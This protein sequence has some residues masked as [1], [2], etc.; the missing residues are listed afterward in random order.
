[1][2]FDEV[3]AIIPARGGSKGI[4]RKNIVDLGGKPLVAY[5][6][7]AALKSP[8]ISRVIVS[9]DDPDI[10]RVSQEYG[11]EVPFLRPRRISGDKA[12]ITEAVKFTLDKLAAGGYQPDFF[13]ELY[14]THP[15]RQQSL[16][17]HLIAKLHEGY[18][19]VQ[20]VRRFSPNRR[21]YFAGDPAGGWQFLRCPSPPEAEKSSLFKSLGLFVGYNRTANHH[22]G[23]YLYPLEDQISLI[24]I[25]SPAQLQLA[26]KVIEGGWFDFDS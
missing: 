5:A 1:M 9:T 21:Q 17:S 15:F 8:A 2:P 23:Y 13:I 6:I 16:L 18:S 24:D 12:I 7:E 4:P 20:T 25:D 22:R 11:A 3:L 19:C 14:P 10:A 26:R